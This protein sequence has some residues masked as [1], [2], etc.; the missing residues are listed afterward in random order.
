MSISVFRKG[1]SFFYLLER[2]VE[3]IP[4]GSTSQFSSLTFVSKFIFKSSLPPTTNEG[5]AW[6]GGGLSW[7]VS[8]SIF[9]TSDFGRDYAWTYSL[10]GKIMH[11]HIYF[12]AILYMDIY[13]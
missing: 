2:L 5:A 3:Y 6:I 13:L 11:G 9:K 8:P 1:V 12:G 4:F 10:E 7:V